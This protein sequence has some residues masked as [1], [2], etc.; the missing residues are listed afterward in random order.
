MGM[1]YHQRLA[2]LA[3]SDLPPVFHVSGN[4]LVYRRP[5][6]R[7]Y[8]RFALSA[9]ATSLCFLWAFSGAT[10]SSILE[11]AF[12]L[13]LLG[14]TIWLLRLALKGDVMAVLERPGIR[15]GESLLPWPRIR[16]IHLAD[17][18]SLLITSDTS[19]RTEGDLVVEFRGVDL[20]P[21]AAAVEQVVFGPSD[22]A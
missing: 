6:F 22:Q 7:A 19:S 16:S 11:I 18:G 21:L 8:G 4:K 17:D 1:E 9:L 13:A 10:D 5:P 14:F 3:A 2:S 20:E 15:V 12:T